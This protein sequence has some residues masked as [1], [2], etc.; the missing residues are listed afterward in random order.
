MS[1]ST[2]KTLSKSEAKRLAAQNS[3]QPSVKTKRTR[4]PKDFD[5]IAGVNAKAPEIKAIETVEREFY[6]LYIIDANDEQALTDIRNSGKVFGEVH[7]DSDKSGMQEN[8]IILAVR[9]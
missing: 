5:P 9:K 1:K 3:T 4:A 7:F 8:E 2:K 6:N